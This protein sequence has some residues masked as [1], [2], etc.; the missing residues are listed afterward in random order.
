LSAKGDP[1]KKKS[2]MTPFPG[3]NEYEKMM[4]DPQVSIDK[5]FST[6]SSTGNL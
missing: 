2:G 1:R 3:I 4:N 5:C 6:P